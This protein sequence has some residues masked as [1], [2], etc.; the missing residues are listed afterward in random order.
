MGAEERG[1]FVGRR[2]VLSASALARK[3]QRAALAVARESDGVVTNSLVDGRVEYSQYSDAAAQTLLEHSHEW[4]VYSMS[5]K[6]QPAVK[7]RQAGFDGLVEA[8]LQFVST[9]S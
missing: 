5:A 6:G 8:A 1:N 9:I 3:R 2:E 4:V 7:L